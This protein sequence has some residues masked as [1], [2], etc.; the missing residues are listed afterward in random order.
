MPVE[1]MRNGKSKTL[2]ITVARL[3]EE[4]AAAESS[5]EAAQKRMGGS[6][7]AS[8]DLKNGKN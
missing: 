2:E 1:V 5:P 8:Y 4:T 7:F 3:V 6:P